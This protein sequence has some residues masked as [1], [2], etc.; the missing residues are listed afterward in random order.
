MLRV[1]P[2]LAKIA[3][4][5]ALF[6]P[7]GCASRAG[8]DSESHFFCSSD[9]ACERFGPGYACVAQRCTFQPITPPTES[10]DGSASD[11]GAGSSGAATVG[12]GGGAGG[13]V[14][15][16][17]GGGGG[18]ATDAE[19]GSG[20]ASSVAEAPRGSGGASSVAD[21]SHPE[22]HSG[23]PA[24]DAR[25]PEDAEVHRFAPIVGIIS[26]G[27]G[28]L[29]F[30]RVE[31][32][33]GEESHRVQL[34]NLSGVSQGITG[35]DPVA[36]RFYALVDFTDQTH[37]LLAL[38][39]NT[40]A[41]VSSPVVGLGLLT[42]E[43]TGAGS[44]FGLAASEVSADS[45]VSQ[46]VDPITGVALKLSDL[47]PQSVGLA[48]G[49]SAIDLVHGRYYQVMNDDKGKQRILSLDTAT[50]HVLSSAVTDASLYDIE[51][52]ADGALF[53]FIVFPDQDSE[54]RLLDPATG[55]T[56]F[57]ARLD[58]ASLYQGD[59]AIDRSARV[60]YHTYGVSEGGSALLSVDLASGH[61]SH[62]PLAHE[63]GEIVVCTTCR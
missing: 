60:I 53:T 18:S 43:V 51:L 34:T 6:A 37:H 13:D 42:V 56:T 25:L 12:G 30:V 27:G 28:G 33:T 15:D 55:T 2:A 8:H 50:G 22:G 31:P 5:V 46:S 58:A 20:G 1:E 49:M 24:P 48:Q 52:D 26:T 59:S 54:L 17:G 21:A 10:P 63:L 36:G 7:E 41:I 4:L 19:R 61:V 3:L 32:T 14:N 23:P 29:A 39:A 11:D 35:W 44:I 57:V 38:D 45:F 9:S 47:P 62:V 40:G 16:T